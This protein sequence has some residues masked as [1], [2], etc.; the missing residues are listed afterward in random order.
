MYD[1]QPEAVTLNIAGSVDLERLP[2]E[3]RSKVTVAPRAAGG[4]AVTWTG[5]AMD[6]GQE[7][8][9]A[10]AMSL[11][12]DRYAAK[13]LSRRS[14]NQ[15]DAPAAIGVKFAV[16]AMAVKEEDRWFVLDD[17]PLEADWSL[18]EMS[19]EL[20]ESQ[21]KIAGGDKRVARLDVNQSGA[22]RKK[23]F[24]DLDE[25]VQLFERSGRD[26]AAALANWLDRQI[27]ETSVSAVDKR[28]FLL[29]AVEHL[30]GSRGFELGL[31]DRNRYTLQEVLASKIAAHR[32][33]AETTAYQ[34]LLDGDAFGVS[35]DCCIAFPAAYP[36]DR[37]CADTYEWEKHFYNDVGA[38]NAAELEVAKF[39]DSLPEV[40][41]WVRN[42]DGPHHVNHAF[43][44]RREHGRFFPDF[45]VEL[46]GEKFLVI[47]YKG[48]HIEEG[49][50]QQK[51]RRVGEMWAAK[52]A[53]EL[54][55]VWATAKTWKS[56]I[57]AA[58]DRLSGG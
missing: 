52:Q 39:V 1:D 24:A 45:V 11:P 31:L 10:T 15:D 3:V 19:A 6:A 32:V 8:A 13:R 50:E 7:S 12:R 51:K 42:L 33:N 55:F 58:V 56:G 46:V 54:A 25:R 5:G 23:F 20:S 49:E 17:Q 2:P 14:W 36:A 48:E 40:V 28:A 37:L 44:L 34:H 22:V 57:V 21:F 38:M 9:L 4:Q 29:R 53:D 47:E 18:A 41:H 26:S 27:R 30:I 35:M 43:W 16:P